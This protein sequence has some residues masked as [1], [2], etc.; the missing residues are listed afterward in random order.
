MKKNDIIESFNFT[1]QTPI[2]MDKPCC[3]KCVDYR[4]FDH[5]YCK[6]TTTYPMLQF[7]ITLTAFETINGKYGLY[8][9]DSPVMNY[10][11]ALSIHH[12]LSPMWDKPGRRPF[13]SI[14]LIGI[15]E[16]GNYFSAQIRK[17]EIDDC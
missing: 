11:E 5:P 1:H 14:S 12:K 17:E 9:Y 8:A 15:D 13:N 4:N 6:N 3:T 16:N 2:N 7:F 10:E